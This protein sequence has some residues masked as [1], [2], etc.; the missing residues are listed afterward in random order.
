MDIFLEGGD[1]FVPHQLLQLV[2]VHIPGRFIGRERMARAMTGDLRDFSQ[3]HG[4]Q[5]HPQIHNELAHVRRKAPC[6]FL[7]V[8]ARFGSKEAD[9]SFF[10]KALGLAIK[11]A[12]RCSRFLRA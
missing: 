11:G 7:R 3:G 1:L 5:F 4:G 12:F 9:H 8:F 2:G 6:G 10:V